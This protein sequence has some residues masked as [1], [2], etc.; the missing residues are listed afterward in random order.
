MTRENAFNKG[1]KQ[2]ATLSK[3]YD[4]DYITNVRMEE[5]VRGHTS[6]HAP[7]LSQAGTFHRILPSFPRLVQ[8]PE[9]GCFYTLLLLL[10]HCFWLYLHRSWVAPRIDPRWSN[11]ISSFASPHPQSSPSCTGCLPAGLQVSSYQMSSYQR[12]ILVLPRICPLLHDTPP[13]H[14]TCGLLTD[15]PPTRT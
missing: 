10:F 14:I 1:T 11:L 9:A 15:S 2:D 8:L 5:K 6:K 7:G 12:G 3:Q 4:L 13:R